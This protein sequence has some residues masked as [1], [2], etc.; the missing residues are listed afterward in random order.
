MDKINDFEAEIGNMF[1]FAPSPSTDAM[2]SAAIQLQARRNRRGKVGGF[3]RK[4]LRWAA[5]VAVLFSLVTGSIFYQVSQ[6]ARERAELELEAQAYLELQGLA[7][8][9][10]LASDAYYDEAQFL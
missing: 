8:D 10:F 4:T 2:L 7:D 3:F 6:A 9:D 5:A 1:D